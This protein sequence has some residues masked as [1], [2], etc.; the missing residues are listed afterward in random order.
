MKF[1]FSPNFTLSKL[2][3]HKISIIKKIDGIF[4]LKE[5][6]CHSLF[7]AAIR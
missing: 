2:W 3:V 4:V 7:K 1:I 5:F 6:K